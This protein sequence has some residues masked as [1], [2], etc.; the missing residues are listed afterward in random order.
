MTRPA[1]FERLLR[2]L[3]RKG[4]S[5]EDAEDLIQEG[6]AALS[7]GDVPLVPHGADTGG[8]ARGSVVNESVWPCRRFGK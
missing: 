4:R 3:R 1:Y 8:P 6:L 5:R 7:G 2:F